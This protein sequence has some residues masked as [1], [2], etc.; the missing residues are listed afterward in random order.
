[1]EALEKLMYNAYQG[2]FY[3]LPQAHKV[4]NRTFTGG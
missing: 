4:G 2:T 1:M 3:A